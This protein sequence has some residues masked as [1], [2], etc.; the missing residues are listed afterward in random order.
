MRFLVETTIFM[1]YVSFRGGTLQGINISPSEGMFE[2][3]FP[4]FPRWDM[5]VPWSVYEGKFP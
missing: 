5:L 4:N 1:G 3:D 2:D